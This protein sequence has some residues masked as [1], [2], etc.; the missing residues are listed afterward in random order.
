M[1]V[2]V[3]DRTH[4][5]AS[6]SSNQRS[7]FPP[8]YRFMPT[9][10]ELIVDYLAK[11]VNNEPIPVAEMSEV[12]LYDSPPYLLAENYPQLGDKEWYFFTP[13][14]RKYPNGNRPSRSVEEV[15][16]WKAT[17]ADR[18]I[19]SANGE[20]IGRKKA[21]VFYV[22]KPRPGDATKTNWIMHEYKLNTPSKSPSCNDKRLDDWVLCR[23][24]QKPNRSNKKQT[25]ADDRVADE[26]DLESP[27]FS[28]NNEIK[29]IE[30]HETNE[31]VIMDQV[32]LNAI[33]DNSSIL[34]N[35]S[36]IRNVDGYHHQAPDNIY[37]NYPC[38]IF[39]HGVAD[40]ITA[41]PIAGRVSLYGQHGSLVNHGMFYAPQFVTNQQPN[42]VGNDPMEILLFNQ[43]RTNSYDS[44]DDYSSDVNVDI[45]FA[46]GCINGDEGH[47]PYDG[48]VQKP[49]C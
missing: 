16:Y 36:F 20:I 27:F 24:Y 34:M 31:L 22:G 13:R 47:A 18:A 4:G 46:D 44:L 14:D 40:P 1:E 33:Q 26:E 49:D 11:K 43:Y 25:D 28:E 3:G 9:D 6:T 12:I 15:G 2:E 19:F 45:K 8:G 7:R 39:D 30:A 38:T 35:N 48:G 21:L 17:G 37:I 42:I 10:Q 29:E 32:T 41:D 23:I 5:V